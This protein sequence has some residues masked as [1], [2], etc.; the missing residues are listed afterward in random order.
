MVLHLAF[1]VNLAVSVTRVLHQFVF[2]VLEGNFLLKR[3]PFAISVPQESIR[4][5]NLLFALHVIPA[6]FP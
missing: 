1:L 6:N 3:P 5:R 4:C 2:R